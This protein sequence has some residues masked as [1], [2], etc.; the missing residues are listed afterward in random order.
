[1]CVAG[2]ADFVFAKDR[3]AEHC[4]RSGIPYA[5]FDSFA[6][7]PALLARLPHSDPAH[8]ISLPL[9]QQE[10]FHHV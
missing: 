3:L 6:D 5:R 1:M 8:A 2:T 9:E 4:E 7:L 10:L